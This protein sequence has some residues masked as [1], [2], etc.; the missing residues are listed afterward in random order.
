MSDAGGE[1]KSK[2]FDKLLLDNEIHVF[3]SAPHTPQQNGRAKQLMRTLNEKSESMRHDTCLSD[4][5][6]EFS[7]AQA[8]HVYNWMSLHRHNW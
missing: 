1:Y 6:W 8:T 2:V 7:F 3:Q 4:S 5:W